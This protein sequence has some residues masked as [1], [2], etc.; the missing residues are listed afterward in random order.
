MVRLKLRVKVLPQEQ[1]SPSKSRLPPPADATLQSF[2]HIVD[3]P[4]NVTLGELADTIKMRYEK[5][6]KRQVPAN[7]A[8]SSLHSFRPES[9]TNEVLD[10]DLEIKKLV[11]DLHDADELDADLTVGDVFI[12]LGKARIDPSDQW[13]A[14]R[15]IQKP[16]Q[17]QPQRYM[18]VVQDWTAPARPPVPLF[19]GVLGRRRRDEFESADDGRGSAEKRMRTNAGG[20]EDRLVSSIERDEPENGPW[21]GTRRWSQ[22]GETSTRPGMLDTPRSYHVEPLRSTGYIQVHEIPDTPSGAAARSPAREV[23]LSNDEA[24]DTK[25]ES[26]GAPDVNSIPL[27]PENEEENAAPREASILPGLRAAAQE[28]TT[29]TS[30]M[31]TPAGTSNAPSIAS[32]IAPAAIPEQPGAPLHARH[33]ILPLPTSKTQSSGNL[34]RPFK[35]QHPT[36]S[37]T[38]ARTS[39]SD[40]RRSSLNNGLDAP[41]GSEYDSAQEQVEVPPRKRRMVSKDDS[42]KNGESSGRRDFRPASKL[43]LQFPALKLPKQRNEDAASHAHPPRNDQDSVDAVPGANFDDNQMNVDD[44]E[45]QVQG[46]AANQ[47]DEE[48]AYDSESDRRREAE[49]ALQAQIDREA[50]E[51]DEE[52]RKRLRRNL[53]SKEYKRKAAE[54]KRLEAEQQKDAEGSGSEYEAETVSGKKAPK[55]SVSKKGKDASEPKPARKARG[56]A[57]GKDGLA[58]EPKVAAEEH[59]VEESQNDLGEAPTAVEKQAAPDQKGKAG[60]QKEPKPRKPRGKKKQDE[61]ASTEPGAVT[62]PDSQPPVNEAARSAPKTVAKRGRKKKANE[63]GDPDPAVDA[64]VTAIMDK[65]PSI[66]TT[67]TGTPNLL[68][69]GKGQ[70]NIN[71]DLLKDPAFRAK[72]MKTSAQ[73]EKTAK[74]KKAK[75]AQRSSVQSVDSAESAQPRRLSFATLPVTGKP[76][77]PSSQEEPSPGQDESPS[78]RRGKPKGDASKPVEATDAS[79]PVTTAE[80][81]VNPTKSKKTPKGQPPPVPRFSET[82]QSETRHIP[83]LPPGFD[84]KIS[85]ELQNA[86]SS[87]EKA[88]FSR[89]FGTSVT[90]DDIRSATEKARAGSSLLRSESPAMK[91]RRGSKS[92]GN[93]KRKSSKTEVEDGTTK[94]SVQPKKTSRLFDPPSWSFEPNEAEKVPSND[95]PGNADGA[96]PESARDQAKTDERSKASLKA[97]SKEKKEPKK[98]AATDSKKQSTL[99]DAIKRGK[100]KQRV[101]NPPTPLKLTSEDDPIILSDDNVSIHS[102]HSDPDDSEV[103]AGP[104]NRILK[105]KRTESEQ[106][107]KSKHNSFDTPETSKK[108]PLAGPTFSNGKL[109]GTSF[110]DALRDRFRSKPAAVQDDAAAQDDTAATPALVNSIIRPTDTSSKSGKKA[111]LLARNIPQAETI[112]ISDSDDHRLGRIKV[113]S[114]ARP[115]PTRRGELV[116]D[117]EENDEEDEEGE[118]DHEDEDGNADAAAK[119][120]PQ[121]PL[122]NSKTEQSSSKATPAPTI[123]SKQNGKSSDK[124]KSTD[125]STSSSAGSA[126]ESEDE[127]ESKSE[128]SHQS[129]QPTTPTLISP[130]NQINESLSQAAESQ[131]KLGSETGESRDSK[132]E[133][134]KEETPK[135]APVKIT[136]VAKRPELAEKPDSG[137]SA[138]SEDE[139]EEADIPKA[140]PV[141]K[142]EPAKKPVL[143]KKPELTKT[144]SKPKSISQTETDSDTGSEEESRAT[145][146]SESESES[147][148]ESTP[149]PRKTTT[150][151]SHKNPFLSK[152]VAKKTSSQ[153]S[154]Q[155]A[156]NISSQSQYR[157][158]L[159]DLKKSISGTGTPTQASGKNTKPAANAASLF[160]SLKDLSSEES[161]S[162]DE[163]ESSGSGSDSDSG[164]KA[165][166]GK[167]KEKAVKESVLPT[168]NTSSQNKTPKEGESLRAEKS[169]KST[170]IFSQSLSQARNSCS[171]Q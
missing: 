117:T 131:S 160:D 90:D 156:F 67:T 71:L 19:P 12:D 95:G 145:A 88:I 159:A 138:D 27:T 112:Q 147:D 77:L 157:S 155:P 83:I 125:Q 149:A 74:N 57:K 101:D 121:E 143:A 102:Q 136:E 56:K 165:P 96:A 30:H 33:P 82:T 163:E 169:A 104:S 9:F 92:E 93:P 140:I 16:S 98:K 110:Q 85:D 100:G 146:E 70:S 29:G 120:K 150:S 164:G 65:Q 153:P 107:L 158:T 144:T 137:E 80:A 130:S 41:S 141:K 62:I 129:A 10:R 111:K 23:A 13:A 79:T 167:E 114:P 81:S 84:P 46:D 43:Q 54:K 128:T 134:S 87:Q 166:K 6:F 135:A 35:P 119:S 113:K 142:S 78:L 42:A 89:M 132:E 44:R 40:R 139:E 15:V 52:E 127:F 47:Q 4:E 64:A 103:H 106:K 75:E 1:L 18:S 66:T 63:D 45:P 116:P 58:E 49:E 32:P 17:N 91:P 152:A 11:D 50:Q 25:S 14:V 3:D 154:S 22:N 118:S 162:E 86:T 34:N 76:N 38:L 28:A 73:R 126:S 8:N 133:E 60:K 51:E 108:N 123:K 124:S 21:N 24:Y 99:T 2:L 97:T 48:A 109:P 36:K 61:D 69:S 53:K 115:A 31:P 72:A 171:S 151:A 105:F 55:K 148:S 68:L 37:G 168:P 170:S 7:R 39:T 26:P 20:D 122:Q 59:P 161:A 5:I 94:V